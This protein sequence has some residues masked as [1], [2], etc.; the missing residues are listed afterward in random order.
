[1]VLPTHEQVFVGMIAGATNAMIW[2]HISSLH[3]IPWCSNA[4]GWKWWCWLFIIPLTLFSWFF[5][6][7]GAKP[8]PRDAASLKQVQWLAPLRS[9]KQTRP[10]DIG[11]SPR[12]SETKVD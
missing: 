2:Y 8:L 12:Q 7:L 11:Y 3:I 9:T 1:V 4:D 5:I 10:N 6:A